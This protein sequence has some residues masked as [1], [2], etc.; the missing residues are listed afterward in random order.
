M[1]FLRTHLAGGFWEEEP[2]PDDEPEVCKNCDG[3]GIVRGLGFPSVAECPC[4]YGT[5]MV[6]R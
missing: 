6:E 4:C 3:T 1:N 5:G 2:E